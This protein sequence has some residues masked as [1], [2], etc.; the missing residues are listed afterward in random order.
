MEL[1]AFRIT[2][3]SKYGN[4]LVRI[5]LASDIYRALL[6]AEEELK[7]GVD[8]LVAIKTIELLDNEPII[9]K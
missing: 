7:A 8:P 5:V 9:V 2:Y 6:H 1:K 3:L 4:L